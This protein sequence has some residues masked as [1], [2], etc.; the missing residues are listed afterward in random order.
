MDRILEEHNRQRRNRA[1]KK[2]AVKAGV[3]AL[4]W[5]APIAMPTACL[6]FAA[7]KVYTDYGNYAI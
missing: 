4:S 3:A 2:V 6:M 1:L 5:Y 7:Y